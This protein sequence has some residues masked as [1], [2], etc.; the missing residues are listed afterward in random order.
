MLKEPK[1]KKPSDFSTVVWAEPIPGH[2][3]MWST[4]TCKCGRALPGVWFPSIQ[5]PAAG[6]ADEG[7]VEDESRSLFSFAF[8]SKRLRGGLSEVVIGP[9]PGSSEAA[10][11]SFTQGAWFGSPLPSRRKRSCDRCVSISLKMNF[12]LKSSRPITCELSDPGSGKTNNNKQEAQE[13]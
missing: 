11:G 6:L 13:L 12:Y 4:C 1:S 5:K 3:W 7:R 10:A 8:V 9:R 2:T